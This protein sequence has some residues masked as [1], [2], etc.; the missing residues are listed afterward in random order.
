MWLTS[1]LATSENQRRLLVSLAAHDDVRIVGPLISAYYWPDME[2][3]A[4]TI[5]EALVRLLPRLKVSDA[6]ILDEKQR[7][8]LRRALGSGNDALI[9]AI[10]KALEQIG[11]E[12]DVKVVQRLAYGRAWTL[13]QKVI[14]EAAAACLPGLQARLERSGNKLLRVTDDHDESLL[15]PSSNAGYTDTLLRPDRTDSSK[16]ERD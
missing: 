14:Q 12:R 5:A 1:R 13:R 8:S 2:V 9:L 15:R 4:A 6:S 16:D 7:E 10:L 11:N 3:H